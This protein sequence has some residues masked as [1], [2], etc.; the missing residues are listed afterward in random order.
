[1]QDKDSMKYRNFFL[2]SLIIVAIFGFCAFLY[3]GFAQG[4]PLNAAGELGITVVVLLFYREVSQDK[5]WEKKSGKNE[6]T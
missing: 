3:V 2:A 5:F 6:K 1:M 4:L